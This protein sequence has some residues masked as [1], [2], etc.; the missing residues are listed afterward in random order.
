MKKQIIGFTGLA[1]A[2]KSTAAQSVM[3]YSVEDFTKMSFA[4]ALRDMLRG[5]GLTDHHFKAGKNDSIPHLGDKTPRQL[6]QTLGTE[7]G[8]G[9]VCQDIW[10]NVMAERMNECCCNIV[11]D[12]VRFD[13][14]AQ[15]I[16]SMG[17][18]VIRL[19]R[20]GT[21]KARM[22]HASEAGVNPSLLAGTITNDFED[23]Y[24]LWTVVKQF[25]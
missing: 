14:E 5:I 17:G 9:L 11:I 15:L 12:D 22:A 8:R 21:E 20:D 2:G 13:N 23:P 1:G 4:D 3:R 24:D 10:I 6:M 7:W 16:K 25:L 19:M 18:R